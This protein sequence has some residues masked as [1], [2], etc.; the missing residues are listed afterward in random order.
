MDSRKEEEASI[1]FSENQTGSN[2]NPGA[3]LQGKRI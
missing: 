2:E 3:D 1:M